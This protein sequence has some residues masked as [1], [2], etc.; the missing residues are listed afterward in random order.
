MSD[1]AVAF[2]HLRAAVTSPPSQEDA[3][4]AALR[5]VSAAIN[6]LAHERDRYR[7]ALEIIA[8]ATHPASY[9]HTLPDGTKVYGRPDDPRNY[10]RRILDGESVT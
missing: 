4:E 2:E 3:I 5:E 7:G 10:A 1:P 9:S 6:S 8:S